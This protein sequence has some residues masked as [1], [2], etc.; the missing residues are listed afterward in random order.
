MTAERDRDA[1]KTELAGLVA[2][3]TEARDHLTSLNYQAT[4][5]Q[6]SIRTRDLAINAKLDELLEAARG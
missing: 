3:N 1:I 5:V 2:L 4:L 6:G